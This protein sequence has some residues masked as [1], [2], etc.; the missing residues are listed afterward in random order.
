MQSVVQVPLFFFFFPKVTSTYLLMHTNYLTAFDIS[1]LSPAIS[2]WSTVSQEGREKTAPRS[3]SNTE[4]LSTRNT[5][6][7]FSNLSG[8]IIW[9][10][11][12][13]IS[14]LSR[15]L[16]DTQG[17]RPAQRWLQH[18]G[19]PLP[20]LG[21]WHGVLYSLFTFSCFLHECQPAKNKDHKSCLLPTL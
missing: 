13:K 5:S 14:F 6:L 1:Q 7:C 8:R 2:L 12:C 3:S 21:P 9:H 16:P 15:A 11:H 20:Q 18:W 10:M 4:L 19:R 17:Q